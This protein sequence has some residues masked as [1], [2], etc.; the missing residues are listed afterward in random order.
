MGCQHGICRRS[1]ILQ[2]MWRKASAPQGLLIFI[3]VQC[4]RTVG[5]VRLIRIPFWV[6]GIPGEICVL[7]IIVLRATILV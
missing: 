5:S 6:Q 1:S 4:T 3:I 2:Y 7:L